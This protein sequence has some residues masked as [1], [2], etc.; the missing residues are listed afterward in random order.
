MT[1]EYNDGTPS[2]IACPFCEANLED[3]VPPEHFRWCREFHEAWDGWLADAPVVDEGAWDVADVSTATVVADG[4]EPHEPGTRR[5]QICDEA[6]PADAVEQRSPASIAPMEAMVCD[7][8]QVIEDHQREDDACMACGE[9]VETGFY[10]ELEHPVGADEVPGFL[11][12]RLCGDCAGE[13]AHRLKYRG[14]ENSNAAHQALLE[15]LDAVALTNDGADD[16]TPRRS[17][18]ADFGH[19]ETTGVQDL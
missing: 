1:L 6:K 8:C 2:L 10:L 14:V 16:N 11:T 17:E 12:A 18:P 15:A 4:G 9:P 3:V 13:T 19:G 5:C 7:T